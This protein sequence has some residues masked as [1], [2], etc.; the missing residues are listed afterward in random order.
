[1]DIEQLKLI[2]WFLGALFFIYKLFDTIKYFH[3]E[4]TF[5]KDVALLFP[6]RVHWIDF[7]NHVEWSRILSDIKKLKKTNIKKLRVKHFQTH[8]GR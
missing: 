1:M 5:K 3:K 2:F 7:E 8:K 6:E 4:D